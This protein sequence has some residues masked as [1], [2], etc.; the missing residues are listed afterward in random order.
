MGVVREKKRESPIQV[1]RIVSLIEKFLILATKL[2][3]DHY[4]IN[5]VIWSI[6]GLWNIG[7]LAIQKKFLKDGEVCSMFKMELC[8]F[9][10]HLYSPFNFPIKTLSQ[11]TSWHWREYFPSVTQTYSSTPK[12]QCSETWAWL[13]AKAF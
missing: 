11:L 13:I 3:S 12:N 5:C 9:F 8:N 10:I 4:W 6:L 7:A 2:I 1:E